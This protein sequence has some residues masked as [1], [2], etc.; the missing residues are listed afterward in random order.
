MEL[1]WSLKEIYP[2][3]DG[4]EFKQD[5]NKLTDIIEEINKWALEATKNKNNLVEKLEDYI[6]RFTKVT[7]LSSRISIFINLSLS[8]N[9]KDKNAL[10]YSDI[11]EKK[12]TNLIG[13][14]VKF[15]RYI[16]SIEGLDEIISKSK[17]LKEHEFML[18][19]IVEQ[20]QYLL[21][22]KEESIIANMKNTGSNAWAK[23]KDNL[24]ST[25]LVEIEEDNEIKHIPL[26]MVLNM[27]Y[28]KDATVRKKAYEAEIKSYKKVEEGVA[29]ALNGIKGE[30][31]T[32]CDF[33]GYKSPLEK[34]LIDSRMSEESLEAMFLAMKESLPVFRKYLRRKGEMLGHKNGLPFY[35]L[36]AP[37]CEAD[38]KFTYE[39]GTKFVEKNFRTF[40]DNLGDF[41]RKAIDNHWIDVKPKEG[42]VGG[43]FCENL[44]FNGESRIL[45][46]YG[47]NF[48]DVVTL[49][50]ELGH[51]FHGE[52]LNNETTLNSDYPMPIAETASTFCETIIKKAAIK[53]ASKN[54]ALAI[55]ETEISDCTQVIVDIY[56]RFLFEK[57]FFEARKGSSL[58][59]EE[60]KDLMLD[61]Q[62]EA[63]GDGL[64]P[65]F[66]HP[67]MW[68]W[69]PHYYDAEYN[70]Y[71]F[72][73]AFGL[74]FAKGL[75]AEYL[76]K[77]KTFSKEYEKLLSITG[78]NK[79]ADVARVMGIDINDTE[80]WR[81]SLKTIEEDIEEFIDLSNK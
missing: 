53:D 49:A 35:D 56:S 3:F 66:L 44:H 23:L 32:V 43:A 18:K 21:S 74:L 81:N 37:V 60:I 30:V 7:D 55:L 69:K 31:L 45:L 51:G 79:I 10:R 29:A 8:V 64:D 62:R 76:K 71:N 12:L 63:Y 68:T 80:F 70:Y 75:Y 39:E 47:D 40:S 14:S 4:D 28:D 19:N 52:C 73:Y 6:N 58:S 42:K 38:M 57:S 16:S 22:D 5:L 9:T 13:S 2:S 78:K 1:N 77:G 24:I 33:R 11:L 20:S 15:E 61:A 41:A 27:A 54:E 67:Y 48:G 34:T 26:T 25:L 72:P 50:H 46:N 36:Y 17:L 65:D 59:V